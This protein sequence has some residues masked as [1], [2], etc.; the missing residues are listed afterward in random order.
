MLATF[1]L[2]LHAQRKR[3]EAL[4]AYS[5]LV[6]VALLLL[7]SES[8]SLPS[9]AFGAVAALFC[10]CAPDLFILFYLLGKTATCTVSQD[11]AL[12]PLLQF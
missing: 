10:V 6:L 4:T 1:L 2:T 3:N 12:V 8:S 5:L 9:T 11:L 7:F